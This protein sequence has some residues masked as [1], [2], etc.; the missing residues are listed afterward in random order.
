MV[1][2]LVKI[3]RRGRAGSQADLV[4]DVD[5]L[6]VFAINLLYEIETTRRRLC[7]ATGEPS[8]RVTLLDVAAAAVASARRILKASRSAPAESSLAEARTWL[9]QA[10]DALE[11]V[12]GSRPE[13]PRS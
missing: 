7:L 11:S 13:G 1:D 4:Q 5:N 2:G 9:V 12:P 6:E 10:K 8:E 3:I